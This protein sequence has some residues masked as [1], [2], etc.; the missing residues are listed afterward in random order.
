MLIFASLLFNGYSQLSLR[1]L[2]EQIDWKTNESMFVYNQHDYIEPMKQEVWDNEG[3]ES[4]FR[5]KNISI[6][7]YP[8]KTSYIRVLCSTKK[9][10]RINFIVLEDE[11]DMSHYSVVKDELIKQFGIPTNDVYD[12]TPSVIQYKNKTKWIMNDYQIEATLIIFGKEYSY[13]IRVEPL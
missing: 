5:F 2:C 11:T 12:N 10:Y 1:N 4:N 6:A 8:V 3:T 9:L 13:T 7:N